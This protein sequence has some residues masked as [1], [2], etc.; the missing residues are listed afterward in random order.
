MSGRLLHAYHEIAQRFRAARG[1]RI[2]SDELAI[3]RAL[4]RLLH[5]P[6]PYID[7]ASLESQ[8]DVPGVDDE[9]Q[10]F[11]KLSVMATATLISTD[12]D[13][14]RALLD[15]AAAQDLDVRAVDPADFDPTQI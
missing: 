11:A 12:G 14:R 3:V 13:L 6:G 1:S 15:Y 8:R 7:D 10:L 9:D 5:S 4:N 2:G